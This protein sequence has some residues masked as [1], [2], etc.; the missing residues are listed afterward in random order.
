MGG[1]GPPAGG[2]LVG[3]S[4]GGR[5]PGNGYCKLCHSNVTSLFD[6]AVSLSESLEICLALFGEGFDAF[7]SVF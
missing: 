7:L 2:W 3:F 6:Q 4:G 5:W 1:I